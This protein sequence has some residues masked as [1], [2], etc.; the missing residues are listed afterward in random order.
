MKETNYI[1]KKQC[2]LR[3]CMQYI[4][5]LVY[6]L[7]ISSIRLRLNIRYKTIMNVY[8]RS[9]N[10][11][12]AIKYPVMKPKRLQSTTA[13]TSTPTPAKQIKK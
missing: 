12:G 8:Q 9:N 10:G 5:N 13:C 2:S 4:K 6:E 1:Q 7:K 3:T 11:H